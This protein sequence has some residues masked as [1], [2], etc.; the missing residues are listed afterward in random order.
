[1]P[2]SSRENAS[3]LDL[4]RIEDTSRARLADR[5]DPAVGPV[6]V[7]LADDVAEHEPVERHPPGDQLAHRGV[8]L[9]DAQV[10]RVEPGRLDGDVG[11]GDEVLVAGERA[12]RG[13]LARPRRRRR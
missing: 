12:Q 11:L 4:S 8:A 9:L 3:T 10:A 2:A 5:V 1:M 13:L 7:V 6:E